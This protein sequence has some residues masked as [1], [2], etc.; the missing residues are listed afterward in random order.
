[1]RGPALVA[2][3]A[4]VL[5][6]GT[7]TTAAARPPGHVAAMRSYVVLYAKHASFA[8]AERDIR[9]ARGG[10]VRPNRAGGRATV[11]APSRGFARTVRAAGSLGGAAQNRVIGRA[12]LKQ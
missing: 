6:A 5:A 8:A 4:A 1:M 7:A 2:T 11:T 3:A 9:R 12:R 10:I